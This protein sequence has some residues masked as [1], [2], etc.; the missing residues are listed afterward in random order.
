MPKNYYLVVDVEVEE[1]GKK[2]GMYAYAIKLSENINIANTLTT[3]ENL[4]CAQIC[5][6]K[7]Y[8][9]ELVTFWND[10]HKNNNEFAF[11]ETF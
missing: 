2:I 11:D 7:K 6:T 10:C 4:K 8:A 9:K 5:L 1:D 3:F